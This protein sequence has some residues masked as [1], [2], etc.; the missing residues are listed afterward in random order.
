NTPTLAFTSDAAQ[1]TFLCALTL[2]G[3][4][5]QFSA[6]TSPTTY[7]AQPDG[8]YTFTVKAT[9]PA[10]NTSQA[11]ASFTLDAT[12]PTVTANPAGGLYQAPQSVVL[13]ASEPA[14]IYYTTDGSAPTTR[15]TSGSTPVTVSVA[16][17]LTLNYFAVDPAGNVGTVVS[18]KYQIGALSFT[19]NPP[20][21]TNSNTPTF[22][23]TDT[24]PG[25]TFLCSL[26]PQTAADALSP[27]TSPI[28]Y[29]AQ[30][31]GKYRFVV[32]DNGGNS[33]QFLFTIDATPPVIT[34]SQNPPNPDLNPS[35]TFAWT[36]NE[37]SAFQCSFG[38]AGGANA[39]SACTSPLTFS[40]L[41][42]GSYVFTLQGTDL[43]GNA[44]ALISYPFNVKSTAPVTVTQAP[45][46]SL[47]G[48]KTAQVGT[49]GTVNTT[50]PLTADA[51]KGVPVTIAWAGSACASAATNCKIDHYV[52][53]ESV[54]GLAF[55]TV[56][57]P[58]PNATS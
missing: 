19:Q 55:S 18:Q 42:D 38:P 14:T 27:C 9:D 56:A 48:L 26:V 32:Q 35:A 1:S 4:V 29:P 10:G 45:K 30:A 44:A 22:A 49:T 50:G 24:A 13:T 52:L 57:L 15:S 54:N 23:F 5:D 37:P 8:A 33:L 21:L 7:P 11:Q 34:L 28:T 36:S 17:S 25:A 43:A 47:V 3:G 31:D 12:P 46:P 20:S 58:S 53:Q 41:A 39:A 51:A 6:C 2:A 16:N 40:N